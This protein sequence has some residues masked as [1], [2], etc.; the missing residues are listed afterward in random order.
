MVGC[1]NG[2]LKNSISR[3]ENAPRKIMQ[4]LIVAYL[5]RLFLRLPCKVIC[6]RRNGIRNAIK[7]KMLFGCRK[8]RLTMPKRNPRARA[9]KAAILSALLKAEI[10]TAA[11]SIQ[12]QKDAPFGNKGQM[13][14]SIQGK[15]IWIMQAIEPTATR[16]RLL[17]K[18]VR[19]KAK[20]DIGKTIEINAKLAAFAASGTL[21]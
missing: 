4:F 15:A 13:A 14:Y 21:V 6:Q 17:G 16:I 19:S 2:S 5:V 3:I 9:R 10:K 1:K 18:I 11:T 8:A 12:V 7:A 20:M